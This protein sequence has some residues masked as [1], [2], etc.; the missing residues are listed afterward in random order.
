MRLNKPISWILSLELVHRSRQS[1]LRKPRLAADLAA[2]EQLQQVALASEAVS[3]IAFHLHALSEGSANP[4]PALCP[5]GDQGYWVGNV[6][7]AGQLISII[8]LSPWSGKLGWYYI[9]PST[10]CVSYLFRL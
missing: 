7:W 10:L 8:I 6:A 1:W 5:A 9:L 4:A 3:P 2:E